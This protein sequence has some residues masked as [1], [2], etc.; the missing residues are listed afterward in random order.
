ML[1]SF[2]SGHV[3][4]VKFNLSFP[5]FRI[6]FPIAALLILWKIMSEINTPSDE[7]ENKNN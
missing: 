2:A 4:D 5:I 7:E 6:I 1:V 3:I